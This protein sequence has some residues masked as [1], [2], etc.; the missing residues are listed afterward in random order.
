[1]AKSTIADVKRYFESG[2]NGKKVSMTELKNL[3]TEDKEYFKTEL[4]KI[5]GFK[6]D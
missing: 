6:K 3:S 1:M 2:I 5:G 4:D